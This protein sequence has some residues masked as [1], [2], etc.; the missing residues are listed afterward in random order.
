MRP[1]FEYGTL[2][3]AYSKFGPYGGK[4]RA[5]KK[6][7]E[8]LYSEYLLQFIRCRAID[9]SDVTQYV[10]LKCPNRKSINSDIM[11]VHTAESTR[12]HTKTY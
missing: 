1:L 10:L 9:S 2:C 12:R 3:S 6:K 5:K 11:N 4:K 7:K 8:L